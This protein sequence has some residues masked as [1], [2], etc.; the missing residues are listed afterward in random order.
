M[1]TSIAKATGGPIARTLTASAGRLLMYH[2]F[3]DGTNP[4]RLSLGVFE[5]HLSYL[6]RHFRVR[7]MSDVART[8]QEGRKLEDRTVV[9]TVDDGY[10]DFA[11]YAYPAL[12]RY[13][14]PAT[15]F[16]V[17]DFIDGHRWLWF[18][19]V[20]YLLRA[21]RAL[22]VDVALEAE[23]LRLDLLTAA[24][25]E[26]AWSA[27]GEQCL[28]MTTTQRAAAIAQLQDV[29]DVMLPP[30]PTAEYAAMSWDDVGRLDPELV[31]FGSHTCSHPVLSRCE[32]PEL[33]HELR[34]SR[35]ALET[36]LRRTVDL[37][38]YP[39]GEAADYDEQSIRAVKAAGYACAV[40]SYGGPLRAP[41]D[42][43]QLARLPAGADVAQFRRSVNG[44]E[45]LADK[46]RAW[47]HAATS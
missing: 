46:Y 8:L 14:V 34:D 41:A 25:R 23:P 7:R 17:T 32:L 2:R 13:R 21:T 36:R 30:V 39:H 26:R 37:F 10:A 9:L 28:R 27:I 47:R 45:F 15:V 18:D 33:E 20:R 4:R 22:R 38:A 24:A 6:T 3:G 44:L 40:V 43:Y 35:R 29:L 19:A 1:M 5:E 11:A 31:E 42:L 16:L 12:Q